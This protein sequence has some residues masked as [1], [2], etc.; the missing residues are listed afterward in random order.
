V[1]RSTTVRHVFNIRE[2]KLQ[3]A[4]VSELQTYWRKT[5]FNAK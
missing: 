2:D 1:G 3:K 4:Q 5:E